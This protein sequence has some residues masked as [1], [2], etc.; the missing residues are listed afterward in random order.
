MVK[1]A[2]WAVPAISAGF[3]V[4]VPAG[5]QA[6]ASKINTM[7]LTITFRFIDQPSIGLLD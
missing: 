4:G 6:L 7:L 5:A 1:A 3:T 2:A